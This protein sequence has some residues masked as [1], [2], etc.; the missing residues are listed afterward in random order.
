MMQRTATV[1]ALSLCLSFATHVLADEEA[2]RLVAAMLA[3][4]PIIDDLRSLTDGVGGRMTGSP[5][6]EAAIQWALQRFA[7]AGVSA[8]MDI[9][10]G[11]AIDAERMALAS[12]AQ[13]EIDLDRLRELA[14][15]GSVFARHGAQAEHVA[16]CDQLVR[17]RGLLDADTDQLGFEA[18]L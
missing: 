16:F 12:G 3:D 1:L 7:D 15:D 4:T 9:S 18:D 8:M 13:I 17:E 11:L 2:E 6:N 14:D 5:E 10:D